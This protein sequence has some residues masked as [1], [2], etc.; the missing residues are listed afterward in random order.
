MTHEAY[1]AGFKDG[2]TMPPSSKFRRILNVLAVGITVISIILLLAGLTIDFL[3]RNRVLEPI[4]LPSAER[5]VEE[6]IIPGIVL[7]EGAEF[8]PGVVDFSF[9]GIGYSIA[10]KTADGVYYG[11][12]E[13]NRSIIGSASLTETELYR[14]YYHRL[15]FDSA[16][17][18]AIDYVVDQ[19]RMIKADQELDDTAYA[20]LIVKY[21]QSIPYDYERAAQIDVEE[22]LPGDPRMPV[23]VLVD[24]TGD[25]DEK[26]MLAAAL[27]NHEG[28]DT[29]L[30]LYRQERHM[31]LGLAGTGSGHM[32]T[33]YEFVELT[34]P[35]YISEIPHEIAGGVKLVSKPEVLKFEGG[36]LWYPQSA[37]D[38][39]AYIIL[40]RDSALAAADPKRA[41]IESTPM[42]QEQ[43]DYEVS[44]YDACYVAF[45]SLR[46]TVDEEGNP[47]NEM[48]FKDRLIAL[49]WLAHN[50]WWR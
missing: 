46:V 10:P 29:S 47:N 34:S 42:T 26:V 14:D 15:T 2:K 33:G 38:E 12:I 48:P 50:Y 43:F 1:F 17:D 25:C 3:S 16:M 5:V 20:E 24:G 49:Q 28:Y 36:T 9:N 18:E 19:L 39:I 7:I 11:A 41:Y 21:V 35:I 44:L 37:V 27:L 23:Q 45:N 40:A 8:I 31:A 4:L 30:F 32:D 6:P 13:M 22:T